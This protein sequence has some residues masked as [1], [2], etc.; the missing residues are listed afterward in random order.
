M[1]E[2]RAMTS[3]EVGVCAALQ[4]DGAFFATL[5]LSQRSKIKDVANVPIDVMP[6]DGM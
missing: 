1:S 6:A 2:Q 5:A 3:H 4:S